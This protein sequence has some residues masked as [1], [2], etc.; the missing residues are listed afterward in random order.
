PDGSANATDADTAPVASEAGAATPPDAGAFA[1]ADGAPAS[2]DGGDPAAEIPP[3]CLGAWCWANP[4][5]QGFRLNAVW[6]SSKHD[7]WAVG[8]TGTVLHLSDGH[9]SLLEYVTKSDLRAVF[10]TASSDVWMVGVNGTALHW[11]GR[12]L[13]VAFTNTPYDLQALWGSSP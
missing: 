10:G 6:G 8:D 4:L 5:P 1:D 12:A 2:A 3:L 11:D 13:S 9:W 7:V